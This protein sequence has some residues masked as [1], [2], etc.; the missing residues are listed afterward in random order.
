M[1]V[2]LHGVVER[3]LIGHEGLLTSVSADNDSDVLARPSGRRRQRSRNFRIGRARD[4]GDAEGPDRPVG[5]LGTRARAA[6][7]IRARSP[8]WS[9]V[10]K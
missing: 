1:S 6:S 10:T 9:P 2:A 5:A 8:V 7:Q 4:G 3:E